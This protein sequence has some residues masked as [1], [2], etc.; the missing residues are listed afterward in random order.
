MKFLL[1]RREMW[2]NVEHNVDITEFSQR[3]ERPNY[4]S[5][6]RNQHKEMLGI[7]YGC[8]GMLILKFLPNE[9]DCREMSIIVDF[10]IIIIFKLLSI[11]DINF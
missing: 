3:K 11:V 5:S 1:N 8:S 4:Y 6:G 10:N 9:I 2:R 7:V